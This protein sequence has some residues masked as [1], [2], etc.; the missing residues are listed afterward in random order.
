[1]SIVLNY[2]YANRKHFQTVLIINAVPILGALIFQWNL[3]EAANVY[4]L[5]MI[6]FYVG[7]T[8]NTA[9]QRHPLAFGYLLSW[10][11]VGIFSFMLFGA[12]FFLFETFEDDIDI[13]KILINYISDPWTIVVF[14]SL[15]ITFSILNWTKLK[16]RRGEL[17]FFDA[18]AKM[19]ITMLG[20]FVFSIPLL[21]MRFL[22][23]IS[24]LVLFLVLK[25]FFDFIVYSELNNRK[26]K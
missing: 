16:I 23:Q 11:F 9:I 6:A 2:I 24:E 10:V 12:I 1:M 22:D 19:T 26:V 15:L 20:T 18:L 7:A 4:W 25:Y 5:E 3:H 17:V 13:P 14:I 21:F 8:I